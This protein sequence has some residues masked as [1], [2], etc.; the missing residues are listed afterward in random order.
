MALHFVPGDEIA[1]RAIHHNHF[2]L[3]QQALGFVPGMELGHG[4]IPGEEEKLH[5]GAVAGFQVAHG[6]DGV[7][8]AIA[9]EFDQRKVEPG[10][11]A[12]R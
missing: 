1:G 7:R 3:A 8:R 11:V 9:L 12:E 10:I 4:I 5:A 2:K 6:V